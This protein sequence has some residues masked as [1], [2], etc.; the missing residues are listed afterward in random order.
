MSP[1]SSGY[2]VNDPRKIQGRDDVFANDRSL[3]GLRLRRALDAIGNGTERTILNPGSGAGRYARALALAR[4]A[5]RIVAGDLSPVAID[6]AR[7]HGGGPEFLVFDAEDL[8]FGE[9]E[10]DAIVFFDLLEHLPHPDVFLAECR[11]V[12][13][14]A[15]R[16]HFFCPLEGQPGTIY[17]MLRDNRPIP[18][19]DWKHD[20]VGHIQ[21]FRDA[22]ILTLV[23]EAG[24]DISDIAYSFHLVGQ[25]HDVVD[26]W[27]RERNSGTPGRLP[28]GL[29]NLISRLVFLFTWRLSY[30]EDRLFSGRALA[31][32]IHVTAISP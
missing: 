30:F 2:D 31:S 7:A 18:I 29:V 23:A 17:H 22:D 19:H 11:R 26:Y 27:Q 6:E 3:A 20:H 15:G 1:R 4:P 10:F 5:W 25:I 14:P 24:F 32:G 12:L 9:G 8:P 21:R 16:L 13:K 28:V